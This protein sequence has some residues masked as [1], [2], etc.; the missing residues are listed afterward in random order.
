MRRTALLATGLAL[1]SLT[2]TAGC[3]VFDQPADLQVYSA[4]HY[5][6]E[7]AFAEFEEQT[8]K[9]VEFIFDD[10]AVLLERIRAE[11]EDSP[12]DVYMSVDAGNLW[13]AA[14]QGVIAP[15]DSPTLTDAVPEGFRDPEGRWFGLALRA[16]TVLYNPDGVEESELDATDTYAGLT[17]PKWQGRL[18]MRDSTE[19][20]LSLIHI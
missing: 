11:G 9:S 16:R 20:Y 14:D 19:A 7:D 18:C 15:L 4:R 3:G 6:V 13:N 1:A 2:A 12:A 5:D 17:D 10:D 8:G